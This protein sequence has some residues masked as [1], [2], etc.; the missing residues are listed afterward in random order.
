MVSTEHELLGRK[1]ALERRVTVAAVIVPFVA[2]VVAVVLMAGGAVSWLDLGCFAA[3]YAL[4]GFGITVGFHRLLTHRSFDAPRPVRIAF[5]VLGSMAVQGELIK[6][7]ADHRKHHTFTDEEG[8]PHSPHLHT[9]DGWRGV[10]R[11]L[12]HSHV[13][14]MVSR[15]EYVPAER[16]AR[17]L[18]N[19][20][21]M[22]FVHRAFVL[23]VALGFAIPFAAGLTI[24]G[25]LTAGLTALLWGGL[26]RVFM[27]HH[28]TFSV[29][30][31]CHMYGGRPFETD[32]ESRNNWVVGLLA[33]GEGWHHNHHAFPTSAK[34]GLRRLQFDP[35][36]WI[37]RALAFVRLARNV[38]TPSPARVAQKLR[39]EIADRGS[40]IA[41]GRR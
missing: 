28:A 8:D 36:W 16:Y 34:H 11:G 9:E 7:V 12:W 31:I 33:L 20:P 10:L 27:L 32:D 25:T 14:W 37:I 41:E 24:G 23:W 35:S 5:A 6:W 40:L 39:P 38:R 3:M 1:S 19:D 21:A 17:D 13:G 22:V 2:F 26:V 15:R 4:T 30:S 29:N 18:V